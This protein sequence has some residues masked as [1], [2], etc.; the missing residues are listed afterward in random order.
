MIKPLIALV[1][2]SYY[3]LGY[4]E[5][6]NSLDYDFIAI[7]ADINNPVLYGYQKQ[8]L[9]VLVADIRDEESIFSSI[10]N[11]KYM[12]KISALISAT[13]YA[14][15]LVAKVAERLGLYHTPYNTALMARNK[16]LARECYAQNG[17]EKHNPNF[18]KI[19][20]LSLAKQEAKKIGYP[21][22]IKPTDC[23]SSQNVFLIRNDVEM[24]NA[25]KLLQ[26][27]NETYLGFKTNKIFLIEKF[28]DGQEFSV[29]LFFS[30]GIAVFASLTEKITTNPPYF[31]ELGHVVPSSIY[32]SM[33][34]DLINVAKQAALSLG[35][36]DGA[37][38]VELRTDNSG[39][40]IIET[41]GRP[42]GDQISTDL[43]I[44]AFDINLFIA[45]IEMYLGKNYD[46]SL[47]KSQASAIMFLTSSKNGFIKDI[48][49][50]EKVKALNG[51]VKALVTLPKNRLVTQPK[52]SGDR[53]G[54]VITVAEDANT[55]K[56]IAQ[57]AINLLEIVY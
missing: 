48:L 39:I 30:K 52:E 57:N 2:P 18:K 6:V 29:E 9:D 16:D 12:N 4:V 20:D 44:N 50:I 54:F 13:D 37:C 23:C 51:V 19:H 8:C 7:V 1:E 36:F 31:V 34:I 45:T 46:L 22:I 49:G 28:I 32:K 17:L 53:L 33:E 15:H 41:N 14:T 38:H 42:A 3:G 26:N 35:F 24:N 10:Q 25:V 27:F 11:S 5:A 21:I 43:L 56:N 40:Y 55:A 47:K